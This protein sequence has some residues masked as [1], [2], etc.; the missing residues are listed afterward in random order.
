[1][2]KIILSITAIALIVISCNKESIVKQPTFIGK[3]S[4]RAINLGL[5]IE[6]GIMVFSSIEALDVKVQELHSMTS[7]ELDLYNQSCSNFTSL[8]RQYQI[9]DKQADAENGISADSTINARLI[10]YSRQYICKCS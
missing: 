5:K 6:E 9:L 10:A 3:Q 2:K 1:M 8:Y 4:M 7:D